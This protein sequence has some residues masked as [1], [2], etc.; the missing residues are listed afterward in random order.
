MNEEERKEAM[1]KE[2]AILAEKYNFK[3]VIFL[4]QE[5]DDTQNIKCRI[6][7]FLNQEDK[8]FDLH[9]FA[10]FWEGCL[11]ISKTLRGISN[12][13]AEH[14]ME[15]VFNKAV[16]EKIIEDRLEKGG[17]KRAD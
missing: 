1:R 13:M 14:L 8:E 5:S 11:R 16:G 6:T 15:K 10:L 9:E 7:I 4:G 17:A 2:I 3:K 12:H